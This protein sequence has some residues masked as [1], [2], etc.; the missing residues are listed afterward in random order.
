M[1]RI[2]T[3]LK[4]EPPLVRSVG[5]SV[6]DILGWL[7]SGK[8]EAEIIVEHPGLEHDDFLAVY[9]HAALVGP[10]AGLAERMREIRAE[11][12]AKLDPKKR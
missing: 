12:K 7:A 3:P 4:D 11:V 6:W 2:T 1:N 9:A 5:I 8:S 10:H